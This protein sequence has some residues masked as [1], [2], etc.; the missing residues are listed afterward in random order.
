MG[1]LPKSRLLP[2]CK[3]YLVSK[4]CQ[5]T[6]MLLTDWRRRCVTSSRGK[7]L[8]VQPKFTPGGNP[9][10]PTIP[11]VNCNYNLISD[12]ISVAVSSIISLDKESLGSEKL[13]SDMVFRG[14][15]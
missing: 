1:T 7:K 12:F 10:L 8:Q 9:S 3:R 5:N 11:L 13:I 14:I 15:K 4:K 6:L 2:C